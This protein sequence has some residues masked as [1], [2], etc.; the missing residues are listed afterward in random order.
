LWIS[1]GLVVTPSSRTGLGKLPD[2]GDVGGVDE[3]FHLG[4][5]SA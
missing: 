3:E 4:H 2:V 5:A 1:E